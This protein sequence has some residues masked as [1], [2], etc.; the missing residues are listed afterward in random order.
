MHGLV[1]FGLDVHIGQTVVRF[2][3]WTLRSR[4]VRWCAV[5]YCN[6]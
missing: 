3:R 2:H 5:R 1:M 6:A 4:L